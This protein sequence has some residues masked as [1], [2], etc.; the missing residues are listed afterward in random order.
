MFALRW[1]A[2]GFLR[3]QTV[4]GWNPPLGSSGR[5]SDF[6]TM[7]VLHCMLGSVPVASSHTD[8]LQSVLLEAGATTRTREPLVGLGHAR[9]RY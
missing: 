3:H 7:I 5:P 2:V 1:I 6:Q 9:A 4:L 8:G